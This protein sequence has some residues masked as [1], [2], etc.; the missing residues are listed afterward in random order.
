MSQELLGD[1]LIEVQHQRELQILDSKKFRL[2]EEHAKC[3]AHHADFVYTALTQSS[4][5]VQSG[6]TL[7][8]SQLVMVLTTVHGVVCFVCCTDC[9][10]AA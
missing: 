8:V 7:K 9:Q 5:Q 1:A 3:T 4:G 2:L 10:G 6:F